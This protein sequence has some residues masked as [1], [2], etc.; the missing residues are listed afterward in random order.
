MSSDLATLRAIDV[1]RKMT[2]NGELIDYDFR[3]I[4]AATG[5][6]PDTVRQEVLNSGA[7]VVQYETP[8]YEPFYSGIAK[9]EI[10]TIRR[11]ASFG[12]F[13]R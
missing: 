3:V 11:A 4:C 8:E 2:F 1:C 13:R 10:S 12:P 6:N 5:A 9:Q 7:H